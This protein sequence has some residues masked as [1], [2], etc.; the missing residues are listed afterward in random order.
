EGYI[1]TLGRGDALAV[2]IV[3]S[4]PAFAALLQSVAR[5]ETGAHVDPAA[6]G[7]H[8]ERLLETPGGSI[9][10]VVHLASVTEISADEAQ[11]IFPAYLAI[12]QRLVA[13]VDGW[14]SR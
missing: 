8:V 14:S 1:E 3:R 11:R 5:L 10:E 4:A 6:A 13:Y 12:V 9:T 7:R 2:L